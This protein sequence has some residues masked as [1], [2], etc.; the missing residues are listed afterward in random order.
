MVRREGTE[1]INAVGFSVPVCS[2]S[3]GL[4]KMG[5]G[6]PGQPGKG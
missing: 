1:E 4:F 3:G 5:R 6:P 2:P